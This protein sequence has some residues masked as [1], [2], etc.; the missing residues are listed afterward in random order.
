[1]FDGKTDN[2]HLPYSY[3]IRSVAYTATHDN[4]T[5]LGWLYELDPET[6]EKVLDYAD[7][8]GPWGQGGGSAPAVRAIIKEVIKSSAALAIVPF[9]DLCGY[10]SDTRT[11]IPGEALGNWEYRM[12]IS[13]AEEIDTGYILS[14]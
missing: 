13:A 3:P 5:T 4:N 9:Q 1:G 14:L 10:G 12:T 8:S 2:P 7:V 11:N 6:R